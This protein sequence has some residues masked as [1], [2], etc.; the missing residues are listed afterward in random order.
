MLGCLGACLWA[1][2]SISSKSVFTG[3]FHTGFRRA[4]STSHAIFLA[5]R[6]LERCEAEG[7]R[8]TLILLDWEKAFDKVDHGKLEE[9]LVRLDFPQKEREFIRHIY[10]NAQFTI[11]QRDATTGK[12]KQHTGI[13]QGCPLSPFIFIALMHLVFHD[14]KSKYNTRRM[15]EPIDGLRFAEI[16]YADDTLIFGGNT[17]CLN[18]YLQAIQE[19]SAYYNLKLNMSK[20]E[21]ISMN[22]GQARVRFQDGTLVPRKEKATYL[23][24]EINNRNTVDKEISCKIAQCKATANKLRLFWSKARADIKWKVQVANAILRSKL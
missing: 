23:G 9:A 2:S 22:V 6:V 20:C 15:I 7:S 12:G 10:D 1:R 17:H 14:I 3:S 4:K 8:A 21:N 11:K 5:R 18:K 16:L 24:A 13:K 19:E